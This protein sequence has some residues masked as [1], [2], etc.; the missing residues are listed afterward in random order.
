MLYY[1]MTKL[2]L[3]NQVSFSATHMQ[4]NLNTLHENITF[5][6]FNGTL[7]L[8]HK[9]NEILGNNMIEVQNCSY[10]EKYLI[11]AFVTENNVSNVHDKI[12]LV[13]RLINDND[14]YTFL[15]YDSESLKNK[16]DFTYLDIEKSDV[17][18][19]LKRKSSL[20]YVIVTMDGKL[21]NVECSISQED[22][23]IGNIT[24]IKSDSNKKSFKFINIPC[25]C[26]DDDNK[27]TPE[28]TNDIITKKIEN[29]TATNQIDFY[30][31]QHSFCMGILNC[32][33]PMFGIE[34]NERVSNLFGV[35]FYGDILIGL[36]NNLNDDDRL[37]DIDDVLFN[38]IEKI[39]NKSNPNTKNK[40]Y[41]NIYYELFN[42]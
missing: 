4:D 19:I 2:G 29:I 16:D 39:F 25:L 22:K 36:E 7:D 10:D 3:L 32:Y 8:F 12:I 20:K 30:Y 21:E 28:E 1:Y 17:E 33:S 40:L 15:G 5:L 37:L 34:K 27:K 11:Q 9:I 14:S 18:L 24:I 42:I 35:D 41:C 38:K 13:K 31:S 26:S 23:N 6:E